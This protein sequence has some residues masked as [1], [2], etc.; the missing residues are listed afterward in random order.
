M[1]LEHPLNTPENVVQLLG[2]IQKLMGAIPYMEKTGEMRDRK[3]AWQFVEASEV[4]KAVH[5]QMDNLKLLFSPEITDKHY[6]E[7]KSKSG[8]QYHHWDI[9]LRIVITD[10]ETGAF[11]VRQW[12]GESI[13]YQDKGLGKALTLCLKYFWLQTLLVGTGGPDP[14]GI[15]PHAPQAPAVSLVQ[16]IKNV[17]I[18]M[19]Q[20][21]GLFEEWNKEAAPVLIEALGG[22]YEKLNEVQDP[23][24]LKGVMTQGILELCRASDELD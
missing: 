13:D 18:D 11:D 15:D 9:D 16:S 24:A 5:T 14:D 3:N 2:K 1:I 21:L 12:A 19:A 4:V 7:G 8:A 22:A 20:E 17:W 6:E 23:K 10:S